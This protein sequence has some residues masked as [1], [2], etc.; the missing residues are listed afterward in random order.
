M[1]DELTPDQEH[2]LEIVKLLTPYLMAIPQ[3]KMNSGSLVVYAKALRNFSIA[4]IETAML[5][6]MR[7]W[8]NF[9]FPTIAD[10]LEQINSMRDMVTGNETPSVDEAWH[11]VLKEIHDAF[12]Y[13]KPKFSTPE[14]TRAALNMGWTTLC[15]LGTNEMN[16]ARA[17]FRDIY[18]GII[19]REKDKKVNNEV[20][21]T[22]PD[23]RLQELVGKTTD[24][25]KLV[26][27][28]VS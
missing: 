20:L 10:I 1:N 26:Q 21:K 22:L 12:I 13:R 14:I 18:N 23:G 15:N 5:K 17:Q 25:L 27:G 8:K 24:R 3:S 28:G 2:R 19:K 9:Y 11:E 16:T 4:E 7:T 6:L